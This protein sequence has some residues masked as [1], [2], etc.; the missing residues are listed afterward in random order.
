MTLKSNLRKLAG[1]K[2]ISLIRRTRSRGRIFILKLVA[3]SSKLSKIY[4]LLFSSHFDREINAVLNG[5]I[6]FLENKAGLEATNY[7]L[8][9]CIHRLEKGLSMPAMKS[10]F[11]VDYI[12]EA[13]E[14]FCRSV[15]SSAGADEVELMWA[16]D[17]LEKYFSICKGPEVIER[18]R[19][20]YESV[21]GCEIFAKTQVPPLVPYPGNRRVGSP[22]SYEAM[23]D[24]VRW[25][26]SVRW[27]EKRPVPRELVDKAI[28]VA[29]YSPSACN[30][31]PFEFRVID[32]KELLVATREL[33]I[34][35]KGFSEG[36]PMMV[37]VVGRLRAYPESRD[38]HVIYVDGGL[39]AMTFMYALES[40][41][42]S[43]CPINWPDV[44][45]RE[46]AAEKVLSLKKDERIVMWMSVGYADEAG[47]I[48]YSAKLSLD[49]I[50]RFN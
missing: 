43:S 8:R 14:S 22:V 9:R 31:Q 13:V 45:E 32:D 41:G 17:V 40:V 44:E 39:A 34:G 27:Y 7:H 26:R 16:K 29:A 49:S 6:Q 30:R 25:R 24:L 38:R 5:H 19:L 36:F 47:F 20:R 1:E 3:R 11:G 4:A 2:N 15:S 42:L 10:V 37:A 46:R 48:P 23:L 21:L 33:P 50:R 12:E 35:V 28:T 18:S